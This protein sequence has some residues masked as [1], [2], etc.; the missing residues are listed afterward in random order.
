MAYI[1]IR[2]AEKME[3]TVKQLADLSMTSVRTLHFYDQSGLLKPCGYGENGYRIYGEKE[4]LRLQQILFFR[5]MDFKLEEI[6]AI[7]DQPGFNLVQALQLHRR[8]IENKIARFNNLLDTVDNTILKI[9]GEME[10]S[11][12]DYYGGF[13]K[14][15]Q[16]QY[17]QE[18]RQ[19]YGSKALDESERRMKNWTKEDF[20]KTNRES[21]LIFTAIRDNMGQGF[22][23]T[24]VQEQ[25]KLLHQWLNKFYTCDLDM[26]LG[27]GHMYNEH[28]G[29]V[30]MYQTKYHENMPGFLLQA[31][32]YY[33]RQASAPAAVN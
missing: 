13:S 17:K 26:L 4:L 29:F 6:K 11:E 27:V 18:I 21:D 15:Q 14:E 33:C 32:E 3:Y 5:E 10:M 28:P 24:A 7:L 23:S 9:R 12:K 30:R 2:R 1:D 16:E 8:M 19:K 25:I 22:D 31:I 20:A